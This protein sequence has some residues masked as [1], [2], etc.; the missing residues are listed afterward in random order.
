MP[1]R[2][3]QKAAPGGVFGGATVTCAD[4]K[5]LRRSRRCRGGRERE[6]G[7]LCRARA[8]ARERER[9]KPREVGSTGEGVEIL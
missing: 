2:D 4:L 6:S 7:A 9:E 1:A 8:R 3:P 5:R